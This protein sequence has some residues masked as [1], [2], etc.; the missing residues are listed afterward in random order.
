M[1]IDVTPE[2]TYSHYMED[3]LHLIGMELLTLPDNCASISHISKFSP[4]RSN[5]T[6]LIMKVY[7]I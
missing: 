4:S 6:S 2:L 3:G 5:C 1:F 7:Y